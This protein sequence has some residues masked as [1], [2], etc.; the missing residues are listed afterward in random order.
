MREPRRQLEL[1]PGKLNRL[2][3][4]E[5][6]TRAAVDDDVT[7]FDSL[8]PADRGSAE[9]RP[10]PSYQLEVGNGTLDDVVCTALER[11]NAIDR[12]GTRLG[13]DDDRD[14]S[15]PGPTRLAL[16]QSAAELRSRRHDEIR[17]GALDEIQRLPVARRA[18]H[19]EAVVAQVLLEVFPT[20]LLGLVEKEGA[21]HTST[22]GTR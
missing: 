11:T 14:V 6:A 4:N 3:A 20:S 21:G 1:S 7:H 17:A 22:L 2:S 10:D 12:V 15:I 18:Q 9:N 19:L 13:D 5:H 16:A 8:V